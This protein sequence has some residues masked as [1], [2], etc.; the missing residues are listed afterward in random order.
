MHFGKKEMLVIILIV[1]IV[2]GAAYYAYRVS[3]QN[4]I[5]TSDAGQALSSAEDE[6]NFT[7]L[8]GNTVSFEEYNKQIRVVNS[9]ATWTPFSRDELILLNKIAGD[10]DD[11]QIVFIA[12]NRNEPQE[13]AKNYLRQLGDLPNINFVQDLDDGYFEAVDGYAMPETLVYDSEGAVTL[14]VRGVVD[15]QKLREHLTRLLSN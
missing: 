11:E 2:A 13:R 5:A 8:E 12:I 4:K 14:H 6:A 3:E 15:E 7:D 9:W 10:F 1:L